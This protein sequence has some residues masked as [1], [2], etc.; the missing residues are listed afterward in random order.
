VPDAP[1][2]VTTLVDF[3][4]RD[5]FDVNVERVTLE[6]PFNRNVLPAGTLTV[7]HAPFGGEPAP[8]LTFRLTDDV[9]HRDP[10]AQ[11]TRYSFDREKGE[12]IVYRPGEVLY[13]VLPVKKDG[14]GGW[15]LTWARSRSE[16]YQF[17]RLVRPPRLHRKDQENIQGELLEE[18]RL[19]FQP[20]HG[21]PTVPDLMPVVILK[22]R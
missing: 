1:D 2:P 19:E 8:V 5:R 7:Y 17:E 22:K 3:L 11:V 20:A 4:G 18:I 10:Q 16:V 15:V 21:V 14:Q 12:A 6:V 13:A 9:G